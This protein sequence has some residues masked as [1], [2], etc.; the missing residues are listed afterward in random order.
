MYISGGDKSSQ[1]QFVCKGLLQEDSTVVVS[2][3]GDMAFLYQMV[4]LI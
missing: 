3:P 4:G 2:S 1:V